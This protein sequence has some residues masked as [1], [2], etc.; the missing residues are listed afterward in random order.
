MSTVQQYGL[1]SIMGTGTL[2]NHM[3]LLMSAVG[4]AVFANLP[5]LFALAVAMGMAKEEK[6][7]AVLSAALSFII[8]HMTIHELLVFPARSC[9]TASWLPPSLPAPWARR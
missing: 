7:V 6:A 8:M 3:F 4:N 2:L 9:R 1:E 5:L